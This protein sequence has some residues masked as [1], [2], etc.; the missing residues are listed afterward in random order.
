MKTYLYIDAFNLYFGA[1]KGTPY[2]WL[3]PLKLAEILL[4]KDSIARIHYFTARVNPRPQDPEQPLRQCMYLR[5]LQTLPN[6][7][8]HYGHFLTH[9]I[10]LPLEQPL[11]DGTRYATVIKSEEKGSDVNLASQ[12]L[13]DGFAG[14]FECAV[15]ITGDSDFL[16]PV[17]IVMDHLHKPVGIINPQKKLCRVLVQQA[18]FYKKIRPGVLQASQFPDELRDAQGAFHKPKKWS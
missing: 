12:L 7:Q 3:N 10:K 14:N 13:F 6:L 5:A 1:L 11:L 2:K 18:S 16:A 17:K 9:P 15:L 8:I 4:T